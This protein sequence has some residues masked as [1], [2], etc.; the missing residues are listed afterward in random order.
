ME[1]KQNEK[2]PTDGEV[3]NMA[4]HLKE[5]YDKKE[6]ELEKLKEENLELKKVILSCYGSI[7]LLDQ[8]FNNILLDRETNSYIIEALRSYLSDI[9]EY[10]ILD[11]ENIL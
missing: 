4:E 3:Y 7:R 8:Q 9:V 5:L 10:Q 11:I 2:E 6:T 1:N